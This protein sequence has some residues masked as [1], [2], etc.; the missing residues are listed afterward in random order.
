MKIHNIYPLNVM[1]RK[2]FS[3]W[4][5]FSPWMTP[6]NADLTVWKYRLEVKGGL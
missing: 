3:A 1:T 6:F 2:Q 4:Y 5:N